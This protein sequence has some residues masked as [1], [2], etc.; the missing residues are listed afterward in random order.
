MRKFRI[1]EVGNSSKESYRRVDSNPIPPTP[2]PYIP[3]LLYKAPIFIDPMAF[4]QRRVQN[5]T[6]N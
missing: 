5:E 2:E 1:L 3:P 6:V 4:Y